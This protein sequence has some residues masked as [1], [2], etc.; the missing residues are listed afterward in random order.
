MSWLDLPSGRIEMEDIPALSGAGEPALVLLHEGLGSVRLWKDFP[1]RLA[2][3]TGRRVVSYSRYGYGS[4]APVARPRAVRYMHDEA[5][6]VLPAVLDRLEV[7]EPVLVGHSDGA[8]IALLHAG[9]GHPVSAVVAMAPHVFVEDC[10][11]EGARAAR[12]AYCDGQLR[13]RLARYHDD[14]DGAFHGWN[15]IWLDPAFRDWSIEDRLAKVSAPLLLVQC[16]DDPYGTLEQLDRIEAAVSG[17][18]E[19]LV[20]DRGGHAPHAADPERVVAAIAALL[21]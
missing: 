10:T 15:D 19:R 12:S 5:D 7:E 4:S 9:D 21:G 20:M 8:S 1:A 3:A 2:G 13:D 17:P 11:I 18:V 6:S 14:V 16:R